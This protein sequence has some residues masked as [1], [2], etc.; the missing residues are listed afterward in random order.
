MKIVWEYVET[1]QDNEPITCPAC[2]SEVQVPDEDVV[3]QQFVCGCGQALQ[4]QHK[5]ARL[6]ELYAK[7][8]VKDGK[9]R[10]KEV[11]TNKEG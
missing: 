1:Y 8:E 11:S 9:D 5:V 3:V 2:D 10:N 4:L 6:H 7:K